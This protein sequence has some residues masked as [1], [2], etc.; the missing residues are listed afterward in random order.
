MR[1][2]GHAVWKSFH[3]NNSVPDALHP[4]VDVLRVEL[5]EVGDAGEQDPG[6]GPSIRKQ[7]L[8]VP[9]STWQE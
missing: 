8:A 9:S 5:G 4:L 2:K 3:T 1:S 6:I 7:L